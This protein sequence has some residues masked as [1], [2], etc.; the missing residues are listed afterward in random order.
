MG[1]PAWLGIIPGTY[2]CPEGFEAL[3]RNPGDEVPGAPG[4]PKGWCFYLSFT[5]CNGGHGPS[6]DTLP[7]EFELVIYH[8]CYSYVK[9]PE[10]M[11]F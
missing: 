11:S 9:L 6:T 1:I 10:G 8:S 3:G 5:V 4:V 7:M 2:G